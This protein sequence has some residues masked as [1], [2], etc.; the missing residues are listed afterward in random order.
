M[1][2]AKY[3]VGAVVI[4]CYLVAWLDRMAISMAVPSMM[5]DLGFSATTVGT[6]MSAFFAGYALFQMPGGMLSDK[7]GPHKVIT[8]A[9]AW[10]SLFTAFTGMVSSLSAMLVIRFLFGV[11]EGVFPGPVWKMIGNWFSKKDRA[12]ANSVILMT[13]A[14]GPALTPL[15]VAPILASYGWRA[16]FY[17][18]GALG[19]VCVLLSWRY[20]SNTPYECKGISKSEIEQFEAEKAIDAK[21]A[22]KAM[23]KA[24]L[25]QLMA[26]PAIWILFV[27]VLALTITIYGY[28]TWLPAYLSKARGM[29]LAKVGVMASVPFFFATI[30]MG[31]SGWLSDKY[32]R[33]NRK[34]LVIVSELLGAF[35]L[36]KFFNVVDMGEAQIYQCVAAFFLYM[37]LGSIWS[38]P[39][40]MIPEHLMGSG[41]G[42]VNTGGQLGGFIAPM[43]V[44]FMIDYFG[45]D[46]VAGFNVVIGSAV[47][48]ALIV[49]IFVKDKKKEVVMP[50]IAAE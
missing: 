48:S 49:A 4:F 45:G 17:I 20:I 8:G 15:I 21:N 30:G 6:I 46:Y 10:W 40:L 16:V 39:V 32:F 27:S 24:T 36:Y 5:Q 19:V 13:V 38:L 28:L 14:L 18:L 34:L 22:D 33:N 25:G 2:N 11:G 29:S 23:E 26:S 12:T 1:M 42:F 43:A 37:A 44:G 3:K 31:L 41:T 7:I 47:L 50:T 9:L 35:A